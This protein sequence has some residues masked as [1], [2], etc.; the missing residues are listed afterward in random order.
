[1][2]AAENGPDPRRW[3]SSSARVRTRSSPPARRA[4]NGGG[5]GRRPAALK[6]GRSSN[7]PSGACSS[8]SSVGVITCTR[9]GPA[10]TLPPHGDAGGRGRR[11]RRSDPGGRRRGDGERHRHA[12]SEAA[13]GP[14]GHPSRIRRTPA[15]AA[16]VEHGHRG[17][18]LRRA[19]GGIGAEQQ[20][21]GGAARASGD[22]G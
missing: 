2:F 11:P 9:T 17:E 7:A 3:R 16:G 8:R 20:E 15:A 1:M 10:T 21:V 13:P 14:H 5:G 4:V 19:G 6:D 22:P 12:G 18:A